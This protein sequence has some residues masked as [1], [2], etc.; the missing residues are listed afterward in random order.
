MISVPFEFWL[1]PGWV[2]YFSHKSWH[3]FSFHSSDIHATKLHTFPKSQTHLTSRFGQN[4][5]QEKSNQNYMLHPTMASLLK[6]ESLL[7]FQTVANLRFPGSENFR[8]LNIP[9]FQ[10]RFSK[11]IFS[12]MFLIKKILAPFSFM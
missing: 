6:Y 7:E 3:S 2:F 4:I 11:I 10:A 8:C 9:I 5:L 12:Q 1:S